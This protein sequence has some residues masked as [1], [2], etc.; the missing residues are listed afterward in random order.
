MTAE[1]GITRPWDYIWDAA[2]PNEPLEHFDGFDYEAEEWQ[3]IELDLSELISFSRWLSEL[4][5]LRHLDYKRAAKSTLTPG[6][7]AAPWID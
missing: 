6:Q 7:K 5:E 3:K 2:S 4:A 1:S